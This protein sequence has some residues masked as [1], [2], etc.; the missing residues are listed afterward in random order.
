MLAM[1][2]RSSG[3]LDLS[4][5]MACMHACMHGRR[6]LELDPAQRATT[7]EVVAQCGSLAAVAAPKP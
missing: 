4:N 2:K 5:S 3:H 1:D 6:L 7:Q